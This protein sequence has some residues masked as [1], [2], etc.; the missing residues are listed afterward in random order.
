MTFVG[1]LACQSW[2]KVMERGDLP[3]LYPRLTQKSSDGTITTTHFVYQVVTGKIR[4]LKLFQA[5]SLGSEAVGQ[6]QITADRNAHDGFLSALSIS[7]QNVT[8]FP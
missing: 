6:D 5:G 3:T 2:K 7:F 1:I 8:S 4:T